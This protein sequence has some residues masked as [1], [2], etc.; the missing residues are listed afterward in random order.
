MGKRNF[1]RKSRKDKIKEMTLSQ[2]LVEV[3]EISFG[4][5]KYS[6][7]CLEHSKLERLIYFL[8]KRISQIGSW[9]YSSRIKE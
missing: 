8:P 7:L 9:A 2:V 5:E 4:V 6:N 3:R 1:G